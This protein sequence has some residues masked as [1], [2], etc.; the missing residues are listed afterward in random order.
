VYLSE[1]EIK[2]T[3]TFD[4]LRQELPEFDYQATLMGL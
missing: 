1:G 4:Q 2:A 3:G